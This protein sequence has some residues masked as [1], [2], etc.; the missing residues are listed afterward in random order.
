MSGQK[1][2]ASMI[3]RFLREDVGG[4]QVARSAV[5]EVGRVEGG[6]ASMGGVRPALEGGLLGGARARRGHLR[7]DERVLEQLLDGAG[8]AVAVERV[9][10]LVAGDDEQRAAPEPAAAAGIVVDDRLLRPGEM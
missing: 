5:G 8:D 3:F 6:V 9:R 2:S 10:V 7:V 4:P 1:T